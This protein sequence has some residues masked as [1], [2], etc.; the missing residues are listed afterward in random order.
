MDQLDQISKSA[1]EVGPS[2]TASTGNKNNF[3]ANFLD[4]P[5]EVGKSVITVKQCFLFLSHTISPDGYH[6]STESCQ[7]V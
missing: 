5:G 6:D 3:P 1:G 7:E 2:T 4:V